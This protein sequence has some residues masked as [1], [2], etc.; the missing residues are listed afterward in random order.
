MFFD[1]KS[2]AAREAAA[3]NAPPP[4]PVPA[5]PQAKISYLEIVKAAPKPARPRTP[6]PWW[7]VNRFIDAMMQIPDFDQC[8]H[9]G[10]DLVDAMRDW[11]RSENIRPC[12]PTAFLSEL[13]ARSTH[14]QW[15]RAWCV[16][17][18]RYPEHGYVLARMKARRRVV[19]RPVLYSFFVPVEASGSH[20]DAACTSG[21]SSMATPDRRAAPARQPRELHAENGERKQRFA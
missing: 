16:D 13:R 9:L 4:A 5:Q 11:C 19:S 1:R 18:E 3:Q 7:I 14:V 10:D 2:R 17:P 6:N 8:L 12:N 15:F 21:G 20:E